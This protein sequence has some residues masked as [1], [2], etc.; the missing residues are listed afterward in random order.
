MFVKKYNIKSWTVDGQQ[1][2]AR[3]IIIIAIAYILS[4]Q[5]NNLNDYARRAEPEV[6]L[7][8]LE[9]KFNGKCIILL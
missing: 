5:W 8:K 3:T 7:E 2:A 9:I 6:G 4:I 1:S